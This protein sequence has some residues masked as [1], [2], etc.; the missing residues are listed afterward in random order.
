[1]RFLEHVVLVLLFV[2]FTLLGGVM[3]WSLRSILLEEEPP[4]APCAPPDP[5]GCCAEYRDT[6]LSHV[7]RF[8]GADCDQWQVAI[9]EC[10]AP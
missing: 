2:G 10:E 3:S 6:S 5:N 4:A 9:P 7:I 1:M 8:V